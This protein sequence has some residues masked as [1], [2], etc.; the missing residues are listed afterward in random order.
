MACETEAADLAAA[1]EQL[2]AKGDALV[3]AQAA[4]GAAQTAYQT[5]LMQYYAAQ[6]VVVRKAAA[7]QACITANPP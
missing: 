6:M 5:A 3:E 7:L 2:S 4:I 1:Q